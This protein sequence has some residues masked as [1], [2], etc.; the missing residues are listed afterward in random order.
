MATLKHL[1]PGIYTLTK[2]V[3]NPHGDGRRR[4]EKWK[5]SKW[6]KGSRWIVAMLHDQY[7]DGP[8]EERDLIAYIRPE[9]SGDDW[10]GIDAKPGCRAAHR[11]AAIAPHL[12]PVPMRDVHDAWLLA[13]CIGSSNEAGRVLQFF[14]GAGALS[15]EQVRRAFELLERKPSAF[16]AVEEHGQ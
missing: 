12:E 2:G 4:A 15:L 16:A 5:V 3:A 14:V 8:W 11:I 7:G 10:V 1:P 13:G 6:A 9:G